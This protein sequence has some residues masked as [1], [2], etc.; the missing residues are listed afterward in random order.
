MRDEGSGI[1]DQ[2]LGI[3]EGA[4]IPSVPQPVPRSALSSEAFAR[5]F[6]AVHEGVYIGAIDES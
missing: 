4:I 2:R 1:E 6:E 3:H 5:L